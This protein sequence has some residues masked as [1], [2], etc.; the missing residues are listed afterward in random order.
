MGSPVT[1]IRNYHS[2]DFNP[3]LQLETEIERLEPGQSL[4]PPSDLMES[5]SHPNHSPMENLLIVEY[6]GEIVGYA[7][8]RPELKIGRV[9]FR[10]LIHPSHH[11]RSLLNKLIDRALSH[12]LELG[13]M[14]LHVNI[15][16]NDLLSRQ[17]LRE[18]GFIIIRRFLEL[19]LDLSRIH[20]SEIN[21]VSYPFRSLQPGEEEKLTYLQNRCFH[22]SWGYNENTL[23]EMMYR[24]HLP[25][26]SLSDILLTFDG[27]KPIAYCWTRIDPQGNKGLG[28]GR[29]RIYMLGVDPDYRGN[30]FGKK[31]LLAGLSYLKRKGLRVIDLTVDSKNQVAYSLYQSV[32]FK[33]WAS[34]LWYEKRLEKSLRTF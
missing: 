33:R 8:M 23:N 20:L 25:P 4:I 15:P 6:Q 13:V 30:G 21:E 16:T 32:G 27:D 29:G 17:L 24:I 5:I 3:L 10:W 1:I 19:R 12:S 9:V 34:T 22:G 7:E 26:S 2:I 14:N 18:R 31:L 28:E 11:R